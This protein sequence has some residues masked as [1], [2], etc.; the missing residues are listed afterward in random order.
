MSGETIV[1]SGF[2]A[3]REVRER[4]NAGTKGGWFGRATVVSKKRVELVI[5]VT[6]RILA[7]APAQ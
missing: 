5:L 3:D 1:M 7:G 6:P 2:P 4:R